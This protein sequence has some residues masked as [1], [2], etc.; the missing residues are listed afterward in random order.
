MQEEKK[1]RK[2]EED[3]EDRERR[4][5]LVAPFISHLGRGIFYKT[6]NSIYTKDEMQQVWKYCAF[7]Y[8]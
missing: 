6:P 8:L 5:Q 2:E 1:R 4:Q 7:F 3:R